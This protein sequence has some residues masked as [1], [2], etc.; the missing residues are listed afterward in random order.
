MSLARRAKKRDTSE[1]AI[2]QA[3]E[4]VGFEVWILDRPCDLAV[5]KAVWPPGIFQLL[6][7][8][9]PYGKKQK[10]RQDPRQEEQIEFLARTRTPVVTTPLE[11]LRAI[12]AIA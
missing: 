3:I 9:T 7:V 4:A 10:A 8:K 1:P 5:R 11:A 2:I 12:G 6:E